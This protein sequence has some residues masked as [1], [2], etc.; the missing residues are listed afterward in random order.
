MEPFLISR[1]T[2]RRTSMMDLLPGTIALLIVAAVFFVIS[3]LFFHEKGFLFHTM[4]IFASKQE[5]ANMNKAPLYRISAKVFLIAGI[6][7]VLLALECLLMTDWLM[8]I[9]LLILFFDCMY[10]YWLTHKVEYPNGRRFR[11]KKK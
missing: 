8:L 7:L 11:K 3:W 10:A 1:D 5:R 4:Y 2:E 6:G 9:A